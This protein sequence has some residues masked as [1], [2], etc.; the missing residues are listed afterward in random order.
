MSKDGKMLFITL[1]LFLVICVILIFNSEKDC[2]T[3]KYQDLH[4]THSQY[5]CHDKKPATCWDKYATEEL[6]IQM[7]EGK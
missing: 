5:D 3:I 6:A 4:G 1:F 2:S 7:C